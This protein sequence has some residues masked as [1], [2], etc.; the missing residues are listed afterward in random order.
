MCTFPMHKQLQITICVSWG[1]LDTENI[2][3]AGIMYLCM[4]VVKHN[5]TAVFTSSCQSSG[6]MWL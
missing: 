2:G 4:C 3:K 5:Y 6:R 1:N